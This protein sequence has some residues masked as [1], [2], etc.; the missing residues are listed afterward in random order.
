VP[1][2]RIRIYVVNG[3]SF[4]NTY[5]FWIKAWLDRETKDQDNAATRSDAVLLS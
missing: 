4:S 2:D 1:A 5:G 3:Y